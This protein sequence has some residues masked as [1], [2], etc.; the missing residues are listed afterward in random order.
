MRDLKAKGAAIFLVTNELDELMA[1]SDRMAVIYHGKI[2]AWRARG[3]VTREELGKLMIGGR[4]TGDL[5]PEDLPPK[6]PA[7]WPAP[8]GDR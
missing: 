5:P 6:T 1:L 8:A 2:V 7:G 3:E 4:G